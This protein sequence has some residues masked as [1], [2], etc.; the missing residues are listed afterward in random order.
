M[1]LGLWLQNSINTKFKWKYNTAAIILLITRE[2]A[3]YC[4]T[5]VH[6]LLQCIY[7]IKFYS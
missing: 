3:A 4:R 5:S 6:C 1:V 2:K 7:Y